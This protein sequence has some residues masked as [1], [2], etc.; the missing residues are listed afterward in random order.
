MKAWRMVAP[1]DGCPFSN[2]KGGTAQRRAL[3]PGRLAAIKRGLLRGETF[4][5]HKT[6]T[7]GDEESA[8]YVPSGGEKLCAG[9]L[10]W[11]N[12]RGASSNYQRVCERLGLD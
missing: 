9:A 11:Q 6:T 4:Y 2:S 3:R 1:C 12:A 10:E 7:M 5:C 8:T